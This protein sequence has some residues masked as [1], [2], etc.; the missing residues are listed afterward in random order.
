MDALPPLSASVYAAGH[1]IGQASRALKQRHFLGR[2]WRAML[3]VALV[4][5]GAMAL[6]TLL[7]GID[8]QGLLLTALAALLSAA[9]LLRYPRLRV[10]R[11]DQL[12]QGPLLA[13]I[14]KTQLWLEARAPELPPEA[15]RMLDPVGIQLDTLALTL[16]GYEGDPPAAAAIRHLVSERLPRLITAH[17]ADRARNGA[18]VSG[19]ERIG[20]DL[21]FL[22]CHLG[23][24]KLDERALKMRLLS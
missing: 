24:G 4:V 20:A 21:A 16:E 3:G 8:S 23:G 18:L 19:L 11:F 9:L 22:T 1:S 2:I 14:G 12:G 6:G 7:G 15:V 10:P 13:V 5:A 17:A